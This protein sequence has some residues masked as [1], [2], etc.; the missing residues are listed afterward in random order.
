MNK[1]T[2]KETPGVVYQEAGNILAWSPPIVLTKGP[3]SVFKVRAGDPGGSDWSGP[4]GPL[5]YQNLG[6]RGFKKKKRKSDM[7][8]KKR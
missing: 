2:G 6:A 4:P 1:L 8:P 3:F 5:K 7:G